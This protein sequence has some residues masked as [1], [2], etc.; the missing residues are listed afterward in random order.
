MPAR[1]LARLLG[2]TPQAVSQWILL[3]TAPTTRR[4]AQVAHALKVPVERLTQGA[5]AAPV[6]PVRQLDIEHAHAVGGQPQLDEG[7]ARHGLW[8]LPKEVVE[9]PGAR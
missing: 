1:E 7:F 4:L 6:L 8:R 9:V 5:N 2:I 3:Q